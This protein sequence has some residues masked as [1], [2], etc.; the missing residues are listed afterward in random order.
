M[1]ANTNLSDELLPTFCQL[2]QYSIFSVGKNWKVWQSLSSSS[3]YKDI[4]LL[5][6]LLNTSTGFND[7]MKSFKTP[8][9]VWCCTNISKTSR[10][11]Y[12]CPG[13]KLWRS[14]GRVGLA[15]GF[16]A[17]GGGNAAKIWI[18]SPIKWKKKS[19]PWWLPNNVKVAR[20]RL[21]LFLSLYI[22]K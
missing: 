3:F 16:I 9:T 15:R 6:N 13:I 8:G 11:C 12:P 18:S 5:H 2:C 22:W 17:L 14:G 7:N 1:S 21:L 4:Y 20:W 10:L 19:L